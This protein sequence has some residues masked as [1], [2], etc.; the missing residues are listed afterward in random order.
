MKKIPLI[1]QRSF[2]Q[3]GRNSIATLHEEVTPGMELV[4]QEGIATQKWDGTACAVIQGKLYKRYDAKRGK[5]PPEGAIPCDIPDPVTGHWPHWVLVGEG[6][7]DKW[8]LLAW[9]KDTLPKDA[10][11]DG[12]YE[13]CGI[14][15]QKNPQGFLVDGFVPHGKTVIY[16]LP[17]TFQGIKDY[18]ESHTMEGIVFW[19]EGEPKAKIRRK[20][21]GFPWP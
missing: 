1:F 15:C 11:P 13:F 2:V 3:V 17:R 14:H 21:F 4:L 8:L 12:T 19:H 5:A 7:E 9:G 20:D 16:N 10:L 6:P 18:L